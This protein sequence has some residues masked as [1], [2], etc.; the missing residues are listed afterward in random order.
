MH[1]A[2]ER[3]LVCRLIGWKI[4]GISQRIYAQASFSAPKVTEMCAT[5]SITQPNKS[6]SDKYTSLPSW[7][8]PLLVAAGVTTAQL[9]DVRLGGKH[10]GLAS[11]RISMSADGTVTQRHAKKPISINCTHAS[12]TV[13]YFHRGEIGFIVSGGRWQ[14]PRY[15]AH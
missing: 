9:C 6:Q 11:P 7:S 2:H 13:Y 3:K 12:L 4:T 1:T 10:P 14:I 8:R 15:R 5:G